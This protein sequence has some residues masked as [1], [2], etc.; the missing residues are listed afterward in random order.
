VERNMPASKRVEKVLTWAKVR[1]LKSIR[2]EAASFPPSEIRK[3]RASSCYH[4]ELDVGRGL[5][6]EG[7]STIEGLR[8]R[9]RKYGRAR[10]VNT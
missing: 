10:E 1:V 6:D 2:V 7:A 8:L 3:L 9:R 4:R 5:K